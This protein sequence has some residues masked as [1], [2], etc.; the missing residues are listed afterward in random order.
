MFKRKLPAVFLLLGMLFSQLAFQPVAA[1]C[2]QAG[3]VSD[4]TI[5]DGTSLAPGVSFTKTWRLRNAGT[6]AWTTSYRLVF[7]DGDP[8]GAPASINLPV[9]VSPG[10]MLDL[11]INMVAPGASGHYRGYWK[12]MNPAGGLFGIGST[13]TDAFWTDINVVANSAVIYDFVAS[14][15]YAQWKSDAGPLPFPGASGDYRGYSARLDY[16]H[17]ENDS[18]DPLP[19]LLTVPQNKYNGYIQA[20]YPEFLVSPGDRLQTLVNCEFSATGCYVTFQI[21][22]LTSSGSTKELWK[23]K[24]AYDGRFYRA[25]ID[26]SKLAGQRVRFVF[27]VLSSGLANGDRAVWGAPRIVRTSSEVPQG[28]PATLTP[29]P[30]LTPTL[31]PFVTA[32]PISASG[33]DKASFVADITVPDGTIFAPA[34]SFTKTWRLKNTGS[35]GW[36]TSYGLIFYSGEQMNAPTFINLPRTVTPGGTVD[37]SL[38]MTAPPTPGK[39]RG[40]WVLQNA[41]GALFGIGSTNFTPFWIEINV[42]G[43]SPTG[44]GYDF[45]SN[46]CS[47]EWKSGAGI[48]PCPGLNGDLAGFVLEQDSA[49]LEDGSISALPSLLVAPQYKYNGYAQGMYPAFTVQPGDRFRAAVGC[50]FG[51]SCYVTFRLDYMNAN[52]GIVTNFWSWREQNEGRIYNADVD[53]TPLAGRSVRFI[54]TVFAAGPATNDRAIWSAPSIVRTMQTPP[55]HTP[56][57]T[58]TPQTNDW[59]TYTNSKYGFGFKY[60]PNGQFLQYEDNALKLLLP[61][62]PGSNLVEKYLQMNVIENISP[63]SSPFARSSMLMTSEAVLINGISFLKE[64]GGDGAAGNYYQWTSYSTPNGNACITL[65]LV[66]HSLNTGAMDPPPPL[67]DQAAETAVLTNIMSTFGLL[68]ATPTPTFFP[69]CTPPVCA[70]GTS[71]TYH[72]PGGDCPGGCGTTCATY[73]P[74]PS[75]PATPIGPYAVTHLSGGDGLAIYSGAG[76]GLPVL[77]SFPADAVNIMRTGNIQQIG[78][79]QWVEVFLPNAG[80]AGWVNAYYLTEYVTHEAFC[81][82][83]RLQP[84]L[85]QLKQAV[86]QSNSAQ[87][88]SLISPL[89]G[90]DVRLWAYQPAVNF[91]RSQAANI[92]TSAEVY[93]WGAGPSAVLDI[94]TFKDVIQPKLADVLNAPNMEVHCDDLTRV[95]NLSNPWPLEYHGV[96]FYN[97]YRPGSPGVD[98]DFRTW[99]IG[100]EYVNNQ[101][102]LYGLVTIVWEP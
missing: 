83:T 30:L 82:D 59:P 76:G 3:F 6:C 92:F 10:K 43:A 87:F 100:I 85:D 41:S 58:P 97:L 2:D 46:V 36:T 55:T 81:T 48:M 49:K 1:A 86:T 79:N 95:F 22:Y 39:Y 4:L 88:S 66:L 17:L 98:L 13:G 34:A 33:C 5:P 91:T 78:N 102:Y 24:E 16:P 32:P 52:G 60:P 74:T 75:T 65:T 80:G 15:P 12:L 8:M 25:D 84:L 90:V 72:C 21:N 68:P 51:T 9:Q 94:G 64:T 38:N 69:Q 96:H 40:Y 61:F 45:A 28:A 71:E 56:S 50:E 63:C 70:I 99:L 67:F 89:H 47:A 14:A 62:A 7:V 23:W 42:A 31:T 35:C 27:L 54:L 77:G 93:N 73:T 11:S 37:L 26:L 101:P 20:T 44:T 29:L 18:F 19:G 57:V 53:L